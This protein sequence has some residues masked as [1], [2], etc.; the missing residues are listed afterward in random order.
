MDIINQNSINILKRF[1]RE[2]NGRIPK[3]ALYSEYP[4]GQRYI[5]ALNTGIRPNIFLDPDT[6][7]FCLT[8]K[9]IES[10]RAHDINI[11]GRVNIDNLPD[12]KREKKERKQKNGNGS[13]QN[14]LELTIERNNH[15]TFKIVVH[16]I[17]KNWIKEQGQNRTLNTDYGSSVTRNWDA[18]E[19]TKYYR[20]N[21]G[22]VDEFFSGQTNIVSNYG[23]N[24][25]IIK[26]A[27]A[28][29]NNTYTV[30][31]KGLVSWEN[32][33]SYG[34]KLIDDVNSFYKNFIKPVNFKVALQFVE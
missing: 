5:S 17:L 3:Q 34:R 29:E 10:L 7:E 32:I 4:Q 26:L 27:C 20:V 23:I 13:I 12:Y 9:G 31:Y 8:K 2:R 19:N 11:T 22:A 24:P 15:L 16:D 18:D 21:L 33:Q 6:Q 28:T 25:L 30:K 14:M 1:L